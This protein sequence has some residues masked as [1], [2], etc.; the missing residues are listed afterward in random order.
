[1][2]RAALLGVLLA[3]LVLPASAHAGLVK[4]NYDPAVAAGEGVTTCLV[5]D[6]IYDRP[7]K[8]TWEWHAMVECDVAL[9]M[10]NEAWWRGGEGGWSPWDFYGGS[11]SGVRTVCSSGG[12]AQGEYQGGRIDHHIRLRAPLGQGWVA[13]PSPDCAG[14]GTDVLDCW[15]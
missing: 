6:N 13:A 10:S 2:T 8:D 11:C 12:E 5:S 9:S 1:M 3:A 4:T 15:L 7:F 14:I